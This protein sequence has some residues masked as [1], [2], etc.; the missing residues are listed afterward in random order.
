L[1]I[2]D[3]R[4][5]IPWT[6]IKVQAF[7]QRIG[8]KMNKMDNIYCYTFFYSSSILTPFVLASR[9][10]WVCIQRTV[11]IS[12]TQRTLVF[13][14]LGYLD[15]FCKSKHITPQILALLGLL[16]CSY[17]LCWTQIDRNKVIRTGKKKKS[18]TINGQELTS[19][20]YTWALKI[21]TNKQ[22]HYG[23]TTG[24]SKV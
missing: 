3:I 5:S 19:V 11:Y 4:A 22:K 14:D 18:K 12:W 7:R 23:S 15:S 9:T 24:H 21:K 20:I 16:F 6:P 1:L 17:F 8:E 10:V 13:R 2:R